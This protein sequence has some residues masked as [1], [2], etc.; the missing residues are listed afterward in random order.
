MAYIELSGKIGRGKRTLVD[1]STLKE[2]GH[3]SWYLND[4]GYAV[5]VYGGVNDRRTVRLH[6]LIMEAPEGLVVDHLNGDR[7]DNRRSN[8]RLCSQKVNSQNRKNT[9]GYTWD[10]SKGLWMVRYKNVFYGRYTTKEEAKEAYSLACSG[11]GRTSKIHPRRKFL[12]KGVYYMQPMAEKG[13]NPYYI[14]PRIN[15]V[16]HF[17]GYFKSSQEAEEAYNNLLAELRG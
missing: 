5:R 7:L 8:L 4:N 9:K 2:Y 13:K 10:K 14:R 11:V 12:P 17:K 6:R 15:G 16:S 3:L 1:D